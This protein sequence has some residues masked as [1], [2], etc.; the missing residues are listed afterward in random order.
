MLIDSHIHIYDPYRSQG[1]PWP[2]ATDRVLYRSVLPEHYRALAVPHGVH[3]GLVVE[4]SAWA[5]DNRWVLDHVQADPYM[6]GEIG[7]LVPGAPGFRHELSRLAQNPLYRGIRR[8]CPDPAMPDMDAYERDLGL[9]ADLGLTLDVM[10][11]GDWEAFERLASRFP[12]LPMVL[13][14]LAHPRAD[15]GEPDRAWAAGIRRAAVHPNVYCKVSGVAES[16]VLRPAP[17]DTAYYA[18]VL[19]V[20]WDAFG[21]GRVVFGSNWPVCELATSFANVLRI[22][23]EFVS[24]RG[25]GAARNLFAD[26]GARAYGWATRQASAAC[27]RVRVVQGD[28]TQVEA[29]AIVNAANATLLGGGGVDGAIHAAAGPEL[30]TECRALGGCEPGEAKV[31]CGYSLPARYVIHTVGPVWRGGEQGEDLVLRRSYR[32]ALERAAELGCRTVAIPSI[33][34]G[35]YGFPKTRAA[36]IA[37]DAVGRHLAQHRLPSEVF[38]V[39]YSDEALASICEALRD[40]VGG[41][42]ADVV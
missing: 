23:E 32:N 1:V 22:A 26:N 33:S 39:A 10:V 7:N 14:H 16:T 17:V 35:A 30:L 34:T 27:G 21:D 8:P 25:A 31:T 40:M 18:P 19:D 12:G 4:A 42:A 3:G 13:C 41:V 37:V 2:P 15:G 20:I 36:R 38:L 5:E 24:G 29:D 6:V 9:V 28:I 11:Q